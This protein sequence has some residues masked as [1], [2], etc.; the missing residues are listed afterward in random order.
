[1]N[2]QGNPEQT[3]LDKTLAELRMLLLAPTGVN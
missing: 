2:E 3:R 1:M